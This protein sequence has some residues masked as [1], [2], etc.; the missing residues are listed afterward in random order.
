MHIVKKL[1]LHLKQGSWHFVLAYVE[2]VVVAMMITTE[3]TF[4]KVRGICSGKQMEWSRI[5]DAISHQLGSG[6]LLSS[7][8]VC[9]C[10]CVLADT[11]SM[12]RVS[13]SSL[14]AQTFVSQSF[15]IVSVLWDYMPIAWSTAPHRLCTT[16]AAPHADKDLLSYSQLKAIWNCVKSVK[17]NLCLSASRLEPDSQWP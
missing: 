17:W 2:N 3:M 11:E 8:W 9:V 4:V 16:I 12:R 1:Y 15:I 5:C 10:M 13:C 6:H 14:R 7:V